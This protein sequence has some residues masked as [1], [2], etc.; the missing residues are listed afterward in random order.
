VA[1]Q[2][3]L[4]DP[5][6][7]AAIAAH[8]YPLVFATLS[9]AHL[10]GFASPDSDVDIR[11]SHRLPLRELVGLDPTRDTVEVMEERDGLE[12]DLVTHDLRKFVTLLLKRNG[13]ALEQL[14]S[15]LVVCSTPA[16]DELRA[17]APGLITRHHVH[18]YRGFAATELALLDNEARRRVKR[19]LYVYRVLLT[20]I[21][22]ARTGRV[23]ADLNLLL[24]DRP[25]L[26][27]VRELIQLKRSGAEEATFG[28][29]AIAPHRRRVEQL[30]AELVEA[31][32]SSAWPER[33]PARD[34]VNDLLI[35][36]R[37]AETG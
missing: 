14:L 11:G 37:L 17:L 15:P 8:P 32:A 24:D 34:A 27:V 35:R 25:D 4:R 5:R 21:H 31:F 6:V 13:Y 19:T 7:L 33:P 2:A 22:L 30:G 29:E 18:H 12:V 36:T 1:E 9:G 3:I 28:D 20:G 26:G 23:E 16:H 10:Y